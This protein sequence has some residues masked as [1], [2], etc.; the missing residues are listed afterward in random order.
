MGCRNTEAPLHFRDWPCNSYTSLLDFPF[1]GNEPCPRI[2]GPVFPLVKTAFFEPRGQICVLFFNN[3]LIV[4]GLSDLS[5]VENVPNRIRFILPAFCFL[6]G[7]W[8]HTWPPGLPA[9]IGC[10]K[11]GIH[12]SQ[13]C[14]SP[15][16]LWSRTR[17]AFSLPEKRI[18]FGKDPGFPSV[19][20]PCLR[21]GGKKKGSPQYR[22]IS[23]RVST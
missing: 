12:T 10:N 9:F 21:N 14:N 23:L 3:L 17:K 15:A 20:I 1:P 5:T 13:K 22:I 6:N 8:G 4:I 16:G 18:R 7:T 2:T 11:N 19:G